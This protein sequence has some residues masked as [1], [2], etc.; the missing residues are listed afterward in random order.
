MITE[1]IRL[2]NLLIVRRQIVKILPRRIPHDNVGFDRV[3]RKNIVPASEILTGEIDTIHTFHFQKEVSRER[4]FLLNAEEALQHVICY[5]KMTVIC[6]RNKCFEIAPLAGRRVKN[7]GAVQPLFEKPVLRD[8]PLRPLQGSEEC[9]Y[10]LAW[11]N[12]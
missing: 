6:N 4:S 2:Q 11:H 1:I 9:A 12:V 7:D 8:N 3:L 5:W 10:R